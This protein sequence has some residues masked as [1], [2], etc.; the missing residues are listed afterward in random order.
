MKAFTLLTIAFILFSCSS[1]KKATTDTGQF[2][3]KHELLDDVTYKI[4]VFSQDKTYGYT[5]SNPIKVGGFMEGPKN[6]RRFLNALAGPNGEKISYY[7]I[8]SCCQFKTK[9]SS[10]GSGMLD[11]YSVTYEG[12]PGEIKLYINMYDADLL[13]VP[14]GFTLKYKHGQQ[15]LAEETNL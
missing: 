6:E 14:V 1:A 11:M 10:F 15:P 13:K 3:G 9:N 7:R 8:G 2:S 5:E 4:D 12:A